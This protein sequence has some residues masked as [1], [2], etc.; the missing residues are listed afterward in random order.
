[1]MAIK[2]I[3][4]PFDPYQELQYY[5]NTQLDHLGAIG[6]TSIFIGTM[7]DFNQ[8]SQV[9][10]M[11]IEHYPGM[12]EK[13]LELCV[14][15]AQGLWSILDSLIV[16]RVGTI[17]P[18]E[19]IVLIAVWSSHRGDAFDAT[20]YIMEALKSTVPFWKKECTDADAE[21]WVLSNT[22]GYQ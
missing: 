17:T 5:Q 10:G 4:Q 13:Q 12:T 6:A 18:N 2:I 8:G 22:S 15:K 1:M 7:R 21:R 16:H 11:S 14:E 9:T 19:V 3:D 20:R